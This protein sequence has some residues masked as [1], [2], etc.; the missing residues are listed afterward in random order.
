MNNAYLTKDIYLFMQ[1]NNMRPNNSIIIPFILLYLMCITHFDEPKWYFYITGN[2]YILC[3]FKPHWNQ[4]SSLLVSRQGISLWINACYMSQMYIIQI[5][6]FRPCKCQTRQELYTTSN[7]PKL[8]V[9]L[10]LILQETD[11]NIML[12]HLTCK[13]K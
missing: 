4:V 12:R 1:W 11:I 13:F 7:A 5:H 8:I 6:F 10:F 9:W 3:F 2:V